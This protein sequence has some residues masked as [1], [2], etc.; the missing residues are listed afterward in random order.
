MIAAEIGVRLTALVDLINAGQRAGVET[1]DIVKKALQN[2]LDNR[3]AI[4]SGNSETKYCPAMLNS[5]VDA[6]RY[7]GKLD[8]IKMY[9]DRTRLSLMDSKK[10]VEAHMDQLGYSFYRS[11]F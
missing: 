11:S 6:A 3:I 1:G 7:T 5:E 8:A 2:I 10:A 4:T 9:K